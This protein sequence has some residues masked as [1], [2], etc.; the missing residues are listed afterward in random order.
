MPSRTWKIVVSVFLA[1]H[2]FAVLVMP[3]PRS[4]VVMKLTPVLVPYMSALGL[5]HTWGFFAPEP[6]SPPHYIDYTLETKAGEKISGRFPPEKDP[7]FFRD[8]YNRRMSLSKFIAASE[9]NLRGMFMNYLCNLYPEAVSARLW[10]VVG[11]QPSLEMV[12]KGEKKMTDSVDYKI[13]V[14]GNYYCVEKSAGGG[15]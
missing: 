15:K 10:R 1:L 11:L 2:L 7:Y 9:D 12:Q 14:L 8:R 4:F 3:N 13:E 5:S 6:V